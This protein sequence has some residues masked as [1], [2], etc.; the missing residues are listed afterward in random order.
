MDRYTQITLSERQVEALRPYAAYWNL[1][2][3]ETASVVA[4]IG[5]EKALNDVGAESTQDADLADLAHYLANKTEGE[6]HV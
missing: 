3:E 6:T 4:R 5:L 1:T 2:L